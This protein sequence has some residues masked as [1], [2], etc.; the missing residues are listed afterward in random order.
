VPEALSITAPL[1]VA[2][3]LV[4][5]ALGKLRDPTSASEGFTAMAVPA[6]LSRPWMI[7]AHPWGEIALAVLLVV[8]AGWLGVVGAVG[9]LVLM[10]AYLGLVARVVQRGEDVDCACFGAWG[11]GR[12][13]MRTVWRNGWLVVV[14]GLSV[15]AALDGQ[16]LPSR[17]AEADAGWWVVGLA[18]AV[19]TAALVL[20]GESEAA[21]TA[22]TQYVGSDDEPD[23]YVRAPTPAV[24]VQL[25]DG[26]TVTLRQLSASRAQLLLFV[27]ERC[28][29]CLAVIGAVPQWR[30]SVPQID[31]RLV[32]GLAA[33]VS[34]VTSTDEPQTVHDVN[35]WARESFGT[36][37]TPSAILLGVDGHLAGGPV[38]GREAV[39]AFVDEIRQQLA[40]PA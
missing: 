29:G 27:S 4:W 7:R 38:I 3:V 24:P 23:D 8:G 19:L 15:W 18:A 28:S 33:E 10:L 31:I 1:L 36:P 12:V 25:A 30:E 17:T 5:S 37:R 21:P 20:L 34:T 40:L 9:S 32:V 26:S 39:P 16:S 35:G 22:F 2:V 13:T 11:P 14:A 6:A